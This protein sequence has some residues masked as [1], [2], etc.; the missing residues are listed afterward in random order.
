MLLIALSATFFFVQRH[1]RLTHKAADIYMNTLT[2]ASI[3]SNANVCGYLCSWWCSS[4][5]S[6]TG[7]A[8]MYDLVG[9]D[10]LLR[11]FGYRRFLL[12]LMVRW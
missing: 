7:K 6:L 11:T 8:K 1:H 2:G 9:K 5:I 12:I 10:T 3:N 4:P